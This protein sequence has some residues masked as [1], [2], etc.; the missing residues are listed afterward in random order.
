MSRNGLDNR[1]S[2][3]ITQRG[4]SEISARAHA[5]RLR[6]LE[7]NSPR[8]PRGGVPANLREAR[9]VQARANSTGPAVFLEDLLF[10][11]SY[12]AERWQQMTE[13]DVAESRPYL[14]Y[15]CARLPDSRP[16]HREKHGLI[17]PISHT[18]WNW[19]Y[20]PN[21]A[22]CACTVMSVSESLLCH[23]G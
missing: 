17:F 14:R 10:R 23:R 3:I 8:G 2:Y 12:A 1:V 16:S 7:E 18:F 15:V 21:G 4:L 19:W 11:F 20:P 22:G 9:R 5:G 6:Y 13:P